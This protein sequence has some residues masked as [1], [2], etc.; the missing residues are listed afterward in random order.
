MAQLL[1]RQIEEDVKERLR[2][3]AKRNGVS[4][5]AEARAILRAELARTDPDDY[6]LGTKIAALFKGIP[7][8]DQPFERKLDQPVRR[9]KFDE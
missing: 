4:V 7:D 9:T 2:K 3:R 5:E 8:N 6:G 1:I